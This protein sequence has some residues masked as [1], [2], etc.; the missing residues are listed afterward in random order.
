MEE[1][2][3]MLT[4]NDFKYSDFWNK[5][6]K[7]EKVFNRIMRDEHLPE[8]CITSDDRAKPLLWLKRFL[9]RHNFDCEIERPSKTKQK[10]IRKLAEKSCRAEYNLWKQAQKQM[11]EEERYRQLKNQRIEHYLA[12]LVAEGRYKDLTEEM[13]ALR[14]VYD[15]WNMTIETYE[16]YED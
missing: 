2:E 1:Q 9:T 13:K 3:Y 5:A 12:W 16:T 15:E 14:S 11:P 4:Q 10:E 7:N 6:L 8:L